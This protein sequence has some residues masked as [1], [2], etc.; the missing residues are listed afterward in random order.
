[1]MNTGVFDRFCKQAYGYCIGLSV[2]LM[3]FSTCAL[4]GN[5][6][7]VFGVI[8]RMNEVTYNECLADI[9][10]TTYD[11]KLFHIQLPI[12]CPKDMQNFERSIVMS[13]SPW[14]N[15]RAS[16][17]WPWMTYEQAIL[18]YKCGLFI[19]FVSLPYYTYLYYSLREREY[20]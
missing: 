10:Y 7:P 14:D 2:V 20:E 3:M 8:T 9:Q 1:M 17:G 19:F 11:D 5:C 4:I 16:I 15:S 13:Y 12:E 18:V 6:I